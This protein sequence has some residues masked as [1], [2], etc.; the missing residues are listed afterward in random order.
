MSV[1]TDMLVGN[2]SRNENAWREKKKKKKGQ[3]NSLKRLITEAL[4]ELY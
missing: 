3:Q 4:T 1:L 2:E